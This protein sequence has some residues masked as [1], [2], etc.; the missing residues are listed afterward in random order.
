[1]GSD[2]METRDK[3]SC[4][5]LF[6]ENVGESQGIIIQHRG[7]LYLTTCHHVIPSKRESYGWK[8]SICAEGSGKPFIK[9]HEGNIG[10]C[11]SCCGENGILGEYEHF[12]GHCPFDLD[13]IL[14]ELK[15]MELHVE[16]SEFVDLQLSIDA[17][18]VLVRD[19]E[20]KRFFQ[21]TNATCFYM[22]MRNIKQQLDLVV[23]EHYFSFPPLPIGQPKISVLRD[24]SYKISCFEVVKDNHF[25]ICGRGS[26]GAPMYV[27]HISEQ[28]VLVGIHTNVEEDEDDEVISD[29][30]CKSYSTNLIWVLYLINLY[31]E[32][33]FSDFPLTKA[34]MHKSLLWAVFLRY[35]KKSLKL[36]EGSLLV[37]IA[38]EIKRDLDRSDS[39]PQLE[40]QDKAMFH[41]VEQFCKLHFM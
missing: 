6:K 16:L 34:A 41:E 5:F 24:W 9:L 15:K 26:S 1:M 35:Q 11:I 13:F 4:C 19:I 40:G 27:P 2:P 37:K 25:D 29:D 21:D 3:K 30:E 28:P 8:G 33:H 31:S 38:E 17:L 10:K 18:K 12:K 23:K 36:K 39:Q 22:Y 14:L 7:Q 32:R 20:P